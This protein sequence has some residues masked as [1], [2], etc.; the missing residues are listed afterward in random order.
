M[1][2]RILKKLTDMTDNIY[3]SIK[4]QV[5][6]GY[7]AIWNPRFQ[8]LHKVMEVLLSEYD[9]YTK[10]LVLQKQYEQFQSFEKNCS[11]LEEEVFIHG[12]FGKMEQIQK[13]LTQ[14]F[15]EIYEELQFAILCYESIE[16][17]IQKI[18]VLEGE[19]EELTQ[20]LVEDYKLKIQNRI[21]QNIAKVQQFDQLPKEEKSDFITHVILFD[22]GK[23][24]NQLLGYLNENERKVEDAFVNLEY[25]VAI[26]KKDMTEEACREYIEKYRLKA[27]KKNPKEF[28]TSRQLMDA[29]EL[30]DKFETWFNSLIGKESSVGKLIKEDNKVFDLPIEER[31]FEAIEGV[32]DSNLGVLNMKDM[33]AAYQEEC[34]E[35]KEQF[36]QEFYGEYEEVQNLMKIVEKANQI[37]PK[38]SIRDVSIADI[39]L[40]DY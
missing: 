17:K 14:S 4:G 36:F 23:L 35:L 31:M 15:Q 37:F 6:N 16:E 9:R 24:E 1:E 27:Q 11:R 29:S 13:N 38:W 19:F 32:I 30:G 39:I 2:D 34:L 18:V 40:G 10:G 12:D 22:E 28:S 20:P 25:T 33:I 5:C 21:Q 7:F 26:S 3:A 8:E